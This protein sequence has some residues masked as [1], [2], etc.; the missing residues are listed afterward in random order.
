MD[1]KALA[2]VVRAAQGDPPNIISNGGTV[3][4]LM[5]QRAL[6]HLRK[7]SSFLIA[8]S[9][10]YLSVRFVKDDRDIYEMFKLKSAPFLMNSAETSD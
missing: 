9:V 7:H 4:G 1:W 6:H 8:S 10:S 2:E 3:D 5:L